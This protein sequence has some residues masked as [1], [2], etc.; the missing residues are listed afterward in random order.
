MLG[1]VFKVHIS[2]LSREVRPNCLLIRDDQF[3]QPDW[4]EIKK[5]I[6]D[7][8]SRD[9]LERDKDNANLF[10]YLTCCDLDDKLLLQLLQIAN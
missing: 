1:R 7:L 8:I 5:R 4:K 2:P 3:A 10:K 9:Y 6:V